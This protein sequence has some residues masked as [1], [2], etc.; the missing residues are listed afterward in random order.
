MLLGGLGLAA[1]A[2]LFDRGIFRADRRGWLVI[3]LLGGALVALFEVAYQYAIAGAGVAGA[4]ALLY[5]SPVMVAVLAWPMLGEALTPARLARAIVVMFGAAL[6]VR[7]GSNVG[8]EA[9]GAGLTAGVAGGIVAAASYAGTTL[10]GRWAAPRYGVMRVLY[11]EIV[12]GTLLLGLILPFVDRAPA[13]PAT[14]GGWLYIVALA[15]LTVVAANVFFFGA[16]KRIE[17]AP[18]AVAATIEP[19][20][21]TLLAL[22]VVGQALTT[23]GWLGLLMVVG[24]VA[25]GYWRE[26]AREPSR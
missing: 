12:G 25:A 9:A 20:V 11:L 14:P 4:A 24:G 26:A 6:A 23:A 3:G 13:P 15:V 1:Y 18:T 7:G 21:A 2:W 17:A 22:L 5:T 16:V 10:L 19:V 8:A